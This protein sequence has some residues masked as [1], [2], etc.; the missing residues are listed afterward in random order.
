MSAPLDSLPKRRHNKLRTEPGTMLA[1]APG[2]DRRK[3]L[4]NRQLAL[5]HYRP[6]K[7]HT[8]YEA[9]AAQRAWLVRQDAC[10]ATPSAR[11][12]LRGLARRTGRGTRERIW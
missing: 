7:P 6:H 3:P 11:R 10:C 5:H 12:P 2:Y 1:Q 9:V 4:A 8:R